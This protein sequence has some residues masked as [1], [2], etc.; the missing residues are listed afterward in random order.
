M[1]Q[2]AEEEKVRRPEM[3][4]AQTEGPEAAAYTMMSAMTA[5]RTVLMAA[6]ATA[7]KARELL[8]ESLERRP[9]HCTAAA[10]DPWITEMVLILPEALVAA[11][12]VCS[13]ETRAPL[14]TAETVLRMALVAARPVHT[15]KCIPAQAIRAS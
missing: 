15:T 7:V 12:T 3:Q 8:R 4:L 5:V 10:E 13:A 2:A 11:E 9:G 6:E 1:R 14:F